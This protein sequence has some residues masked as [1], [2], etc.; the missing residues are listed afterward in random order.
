MLPQFSFF[1]GQDLQ[2]RLY[3]SEQAR[4]AVAVAGERLRSELAQKD[5]AAEEQRAELQKKDDEPV[6]IPQKHF[7]FF[8]SNALPW[9]TAT[10][11]VL[12]SP[13][14]SAVPFGIYCLCPPATYGDASVL[15][16]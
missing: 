4:W 10:A 2:R 13:E 3:Q 6:E 16:G 8:R 5:H 1:C 15:G 7:C 14:C 11:R 9:H 12:L